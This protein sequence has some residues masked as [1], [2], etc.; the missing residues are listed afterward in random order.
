M[1]VLQQTKGFPWPCVR[2]SRVSFYLDFVS[3]VVVAP[4]A[5]YDFHRFVGR[6]VMVLGKLSDRE[7]LVEELQVHLFVSC[8]WSLKYSLYNSS[9]SSSVE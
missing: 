1:L 2:L 5:C 7:E 8:H 9:I 3:R 4:A 6:D